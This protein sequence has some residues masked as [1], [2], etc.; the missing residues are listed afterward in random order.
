MP[1]QTRVG[2]T[3]KLSG[4]MFSRPDKRVQRA[5]RDVTQDLVER[6]T[7]LVKRQLYFGHGLIEGTLRRSITGQMIGPMQGRIETNVIYGAYIEGTSR[8]NE[9]TRFKGYS[10][11]RRSTQELQKMAPMLMR[12]RLKRAF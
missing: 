12:I 7:Q 5:L 1:P 9:T 8:R 2:M 4:P 3:V 10:M 6:G 11:F